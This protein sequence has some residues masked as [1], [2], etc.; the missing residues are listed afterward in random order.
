MM[1]GIEMNIVIITYN[2]YINKYRRFSLTAIA[3]DDIPIERLR[4]HM[5]ILHFQNISETVFN[6][7]S[8][9]TS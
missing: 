8:G 3:G 7:N 5:T 4:K 2:I 9:K 6:A 1:S